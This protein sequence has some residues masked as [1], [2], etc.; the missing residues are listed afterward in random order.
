M[1]QPLRVRRRRGR[2]LSAAVLTAVA[3]TALPGGASAAPQPAGA[4]VQAANRLDITMQAQEKTNWC[5]AASG[6]TIATWYGKNYSQ[7]QFCNAAFNRQQN[8]TCPN[9]QATLGNVQNALDWM[10]VNPG[11]YVTGWLRY[12]TVQSEINAK[13]PVETRIQWSS[14][15][16]HMH[17]IY[18][19][20]ASRNWVYWGDPWA[21]NN[22]YNWGD[23]D[24]YVN[25]SS[26]S[27]THSLYRIGA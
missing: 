5:W 1:S 4:A 12:T 11:S 20:D 7:N 24:N 26:F 23:F 21:T 8:S 25:G 18:G 9:N 19:Y 2:R 10:G 27:W 6:N 13:R 17:V 14:G 16:G 22:R 3:L 15:G